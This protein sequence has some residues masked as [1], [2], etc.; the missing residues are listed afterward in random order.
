MSRRYDVCA[1]VVSDLPFDARVWKQARSLA[2]RGYSV[3]LIGCRYDL[4]APV[5]RVEDGVDVLEL[6]F[7]SRAEDVSIGRRALTLLRLWL[8]ILRTDARVYHAHN[9]HPGPAAFVASRFRRGRLVYDGHEL[10]GEEAD[11]A[12][13]PEGRLFTWLSAKAERFFVRRSDIVLTTNL[14]RAEVLRRRHGRESIEVL[15]NVPARVHDVDPLDPGFPPNG[16][17]LLYQGGIY[18]S[19]AFEEVVRA[20]ELLEDKAVQLVILGFGRDSA[21]E[22]I[23]GWARDAGVAARVHFLPARPFD[24][25]VRTAASA[26]IGIVPLRGDT[27]NR[28]LGDTNKLH[29]YLMAGL[30]VVASDLPELRRVVCEGEPRVGELFDPSDP[31]SIAAAVRRVLDPDLYRARR[32]EARRLAMDRFNWEVEERKLLAAYA[33]IALPTRTAGG[34]DA[35]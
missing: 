6:P 11:Q 4:A 24:E 8:A 10:Y 1:A 14:S 23:R 12:G 9:I 22:R 19:R 31:T 7:G 20:L 32:R 25:L 30:P 17:V 28:Y 5:H 33:T 16:P 35:R 3:S 27:L 2:R 13:L 34:G 26:T 21:I 15:A 18:A 29:E